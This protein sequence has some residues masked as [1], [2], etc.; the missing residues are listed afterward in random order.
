MWA[1]DAGSFFD[2]GKHFDGGEWR[3]ESF[4]DNAEIVKFGRTYP[5]TNQ[6]GFASYPTIIYNYYEREP[7]LIYEENR[8]LHTAKFVKTIDLDR[9]IYTGLSA[10]ELVECYYE[11]L[12]KYG[13]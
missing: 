11:L 7:P 12:N 8:S 2:I 3:T 10:E 4:K 1:Q 6:S 5:I 9:K 13:G